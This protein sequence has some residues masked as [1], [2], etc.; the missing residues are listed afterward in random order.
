M[1]N[2]ILY[3]DDV[4]WRHETNAAQK[5]FDCADS[6]M[7]IKPDTMVIGRFSVLPFYKEQERDIQLAKSRLINTYEQH[8]YVADIK[9]WTHDLERENLTPKTWYR[10]EDLPEDGPFILKGETNSKKY[11]WKTH[12]FAKNKR[13]AIDVHSRLLQDSLISYQDIVIRQY[14]PLHT[15]MEGLQELPITKEFR[16]FILYGHILC[17]GYY[18]SSHVEDLESIPNISEVPQEFLQK[19][20]KTIRG[21]INFYTID[22]AQTATGDWIVIELN[23]GCMSGL[24]E[25]NPEELYSNMK[26]VLN[27]GVR[28]DHNSFCSRATGDVNDCICADWDNP[29]AS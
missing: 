11:Y 10:L 15:Y 19:V 7:L 26:K 4:D 6:R 12:M 16:F 23:D 22:V 14:V 8:R 3:R 17:G 28:K 27:S 18:W 1:K 5:H 20:I 13:E 29:D 21:Q 25:N 2:I 9:E 24:S